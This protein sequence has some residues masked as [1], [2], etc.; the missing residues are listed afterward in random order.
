MVKLSHHEH[1]AKLLE[2]LMLNVKLNPQKTTE[3]TD[4]KSCNSLQITKLLHM[5]TLSRQKG[6]V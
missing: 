6:H 5:W 4:A 2:Y 1:H 3:T